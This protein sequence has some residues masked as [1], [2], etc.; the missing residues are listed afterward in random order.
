MEPKYRKVNSDIRRI[1]AIIAP[2]WMPEAVLAV[3]GIL[4]LLLHIPLTVFPLGAD[5]G[6]WSTVGMALANGKVFYRDLL[7]FHLPGLGFAYRAAFLF[8]DDP[9]VATVLLSALGSLVIVAGLYLLLSETISRSAGAWAALLFAVQFPTSVEYL[10]ISEKDFMTV[11]A[12]LLATW[13]IARSG[14]GRHMRRWSLFG[15]GFMIGIASLFKPVMALAGPVIAAGY[16]LAFISKHRH[17]RLPR[18]WQQLFIDLTVLLSGALSIISSFILYLAVN[19]TLHDACISVFS[20]A[21]N[22]GMTNNLSAYKLLWRL[23]SKFTFLMG[24]GYSLGLLLL[25][26]GMIACVVSTGTKRRFWILIPLLISGATFLLQRKGFPYHAIPWKISLFLIAGCG[27]SWIW[28]DRTRDDGKPWG[29]VSFAFALYLTTAIMVM[30][31]QSL[32]M[33]NWANRTVPAWKNDIPRSEYLTRYFTHDKYPPNP[34]YI[35]NLAEFLHSNTKPDDTILMWGA[36][37][38]LYS[39]SHRM[40]A[41][42]TPFDYL[43]TNES[44]SLGAPRWQTE[45]RE[46]FISLLNSQK[47]EFIVVVTNDVT[48]VEP[49]AS[50]EAIA[51]IPGFQEIIDQNYTFVETVGIFKVFSRNHL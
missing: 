44:V 3:S 11:P 50:D 20:V 41:T 10:D 18:Q 6:I 38:Q 33:G 25:I 49:V 12:I 28:R 27:I 9:K 43:L 51:L 40:Y 35:E 24:K 16:L 15:S 7:H 31:L 22:Y 48:C 17:S 46:T 26:I 34:L 36:V 21:Y 2:R 23:Y 4:V 13:L 1:R 30:L 29:A 37:C 19:G 8:T 42:Q 39:L 32:W 14:Q 5:Q 47:P 45:K